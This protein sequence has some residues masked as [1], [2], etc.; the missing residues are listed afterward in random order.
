MSADRK[1]RLDRL[2][3]EKE[4][5]LSNTQQMAESVGEA[6]IELPV[7]QSEKD[8]EEEAE[9]AAEVTED[10]LGNL[11]DDED[12]KVC[13]LYERIGGSSSVVIIGFTLKHD[14]IYAEHLNRSLPSVLW[15]LHSL[16]NHTR[17]MVCLFFELFTLL[18]SS[19]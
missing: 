15:S 6:M 13:M 18:S 14:Y 7:M 16:N 10:S 5:L 8:E 3:A 1:E 11:W 19:F 9:L 2:R 12:T 17:N 4:K